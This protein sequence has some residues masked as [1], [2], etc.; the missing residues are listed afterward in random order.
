[1]RE[2]GAIVL[3][4]IAAVVCVALISFDAHD[5]GYSVAFSGAAAVVHNRIG[6]VGAWFA[7]VLYFLFGRAAYLLPLMLGFAAWRLTRARAGTA[8]PA[9]LNALL[10]AAG[11]VALLVA[12]C[13]LAALHWNGEGLPEGA[14]G[15]VGKEAGAG[16]ASGLD[17]L[18]ATLLLLA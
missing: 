5:P 12:S 8:R 2:S 11:F 15:V 6:P 16:L 17:L 9:R 7:N 18:G 1:L 4:V 3:S 13:A 10:R 14:G